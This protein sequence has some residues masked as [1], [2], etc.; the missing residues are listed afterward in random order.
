MPAVATKRALFAI[1]TLALLPR[2]VAVET[3]PGMPSVVDPANLYSETA[4]GKLSS[5]LAG[6]LERIY[7]PHVQSNDVYVIDP[8]TF[9][10]IDKFKVGL[11]PQH[12]VPSYDLQTLWVTNNA[13]RTPHGSLT[14]IDPKTGKPG[15]AIPVDDPYN[16]YFSP[17]QCRM[18]QLLRCDVTAR[19]LNH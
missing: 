10:V 12:V 7:V 19:S 11:N 16:M 18:F 13:E 1:A 5:T 15:K 3:V 9:K 14:P 8:A 2:A 4:A 6:H 17:P